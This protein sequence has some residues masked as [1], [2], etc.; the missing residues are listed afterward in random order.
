MSEL[1]DK[2]EG[3]INTHENGS[4]LDPTPISERGIKLAGTIEELIK[5]HGEERYREGFKD[6]KQAK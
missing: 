6:G 2:I 3:I 5:E 1:R 4:E